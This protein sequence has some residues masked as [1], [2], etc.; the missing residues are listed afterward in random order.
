M[1][2]TNDSDILKSD[3]LKGPDIT[4][5]HGTREFDLYSLTQCDLI[6]GPP[7]TF[8]GWASFYGSVPLNCITHKNQIIQT[9][10][11]KIISG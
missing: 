1:I 7:S 11:F 9:S 3:L 8:S 4:F 2:C 5:S 10:D 6:V